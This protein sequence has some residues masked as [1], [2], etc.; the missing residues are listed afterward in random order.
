M[1]GEMSKT[2]RLVEMARKE[3]DR[4]RGFEC[5][6]LDLSMLTAEVWASDSSMQSVR[7]NRHAAVRF[8][9]SR[10]LTVL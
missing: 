3:I 9:D 2:F 6:L 1:S 5:D 8:A 7:L 10:P 4:A